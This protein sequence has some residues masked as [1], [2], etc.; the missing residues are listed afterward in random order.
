MIKTLSVEF[1]IC[2]DLYYIQVT[3]GEHNTEKKG[4][5]SLNERKLTVRKL[6]I[7]PD[8][9]YDRE[10]G[11]TLFND[12]SILYLDQEVDLSTYTPAC[13]PKANDFTSFNGKMA[14]VVGKFIILEHFPAWKHKDT[15]KGKK[16]DWC[17][18][19]CLYDIR[20][21]A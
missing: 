19:L 17:L 3:I 18:Q 13:L 15:T 14:L 5:G 12:I 9:D 7:H 16:C 1:G 4:E 21:L 20:E 6:I 2:Q 11:S 10:T 8:F